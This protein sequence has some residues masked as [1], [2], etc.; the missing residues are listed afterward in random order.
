MSLKIMVVDNEPK[1][2]QLMRAVATP[3]GHSVLPFRDYREAAEKAEAQSFDVAFV[4][5]RL[6]N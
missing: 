4:G 5:M 6:L 1:I 2:A 3:L